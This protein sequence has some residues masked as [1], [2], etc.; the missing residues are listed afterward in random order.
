MSLTVYVIAGIAIVIIGLI[1]C[2]SIKVAQAKKTIAHY[3]Q[4]AQQLQQQ[5]AVADTQVKNYQEKAKNE[6]NNRG[7]SRDDVINRLQQAGDLR[8]E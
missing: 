6:E 8:D 7:V 5:K 1:A 2:F 3:Q 4:I